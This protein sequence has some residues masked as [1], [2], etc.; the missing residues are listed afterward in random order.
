MKR[1]FD[2]KYSVWLLEIV[3]IGVLV[4]VL[5]FVWML[6]VSIDIQYIP[7][8]MS[9]LTSGTAILIG[10]A[11]ACL[12]IM[13][14]YYAKNVG[15]LIVFLSYLVLPIVFLFLAYLRLVLRTDFIV[16]IRLA[17]S[18]FALSLIIFFM[19]LFSAIKEHW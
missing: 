8:I 15:K 19:V 3:M 10:F 1:F 16:A 6:D 4:L 14:K 12:T 18:G 5:I 2:S 17:V 11:A 9:G 7:E 13:R